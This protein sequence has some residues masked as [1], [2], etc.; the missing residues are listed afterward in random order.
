MKTGLMAAFVLCSFSALAQRDTLAINNDWRF[1]TDKK[2][3][4]LKANWFAADLVGGRTVA[5]PHTWNVEPANQNF[6]GWGWY[7]KK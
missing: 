5:L 7:Q 1:T 4:G 3:E 6:Y 2:A